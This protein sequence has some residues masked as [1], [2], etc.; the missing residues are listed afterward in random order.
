MVLMIS[1]R[2]EACGRLAVSKESGMT[3]GITDQAVTRV[4]QDAHD[5]KDEHACVDS[6]V[7]ENV[8]AQLEAI[9]S[10]MYADH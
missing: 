8:I 10:R 1:L 3:G 9:K 6:L 2:K 7:H 4:I 5:H